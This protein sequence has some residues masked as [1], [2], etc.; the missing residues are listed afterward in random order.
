MILLLLLLLAS[1]ALLLW[2]ANG[3]RSPSLWVRIGTGAAIAAVL[4]LM[5]WLLVMLISLA[6]HMTGM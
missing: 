5:A 6:Q 3:F 1:L 2:I 4:S